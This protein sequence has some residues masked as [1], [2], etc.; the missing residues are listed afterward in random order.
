MA[1]TILPKEKTKRVGVVA[2]VWIM[3][4]SFSPFQKV[5]DEHGCPPFCSVLTDVTLENQFV[6]GCEDVRR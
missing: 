4:E 3:A 1:F 6:M 2:I 5:L